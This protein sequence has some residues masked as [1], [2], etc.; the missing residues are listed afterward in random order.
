[1]DSIHR[2]QIE[3]IAAARRSLTLGDD[4]TN[5]KV[6]LTSLGAGVQSVTLNK[7]QA[8][9]RHGLPQPR[10]LPLIPREDANGKKLPPAFRLYHFKPGP[11]DPNARPWDTLGNLDWTLVEDSIKKSTTDDGKEITTEA[12]FTTEVPGEDVILS[13]T[14]TLAPGDY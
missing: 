5:L 14:Y 8:A 7:F 9:D 10:R 1:L 12:T 6:E 13:K 11:D 2:K 3:K 4:S